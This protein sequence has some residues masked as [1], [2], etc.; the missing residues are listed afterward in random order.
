MLILFYIKIVFILNFF[1]KYFW[2][3]SDICI[4]KHYF[5]T[6]ESRIKNLILCNVEVYESLSQLILFLNN[7][8][9]KFL[10]IYNKKK[11]K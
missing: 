11:Y 1:I 4:R 7:Y 6:T 5:F 8:S 3:K 10:T 9:F 2:L